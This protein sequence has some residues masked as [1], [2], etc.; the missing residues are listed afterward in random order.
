[1]IRNYH[2]DTEGKTETQ[3]GVESVSANFAQR[4]SADPYNCEFSLEN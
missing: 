4:I 1:M 2:A 3:N